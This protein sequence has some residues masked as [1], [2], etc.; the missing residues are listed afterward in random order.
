MPLVWPN[1]P[2]LESVSV[3]IPLKLVNCSDQLISTKTFAA[4]TRI[5]F[6]F[7]RW[8][9]YLS[10]YD[11]WGQLAVFYLWVVGESNSKISLTSINVINFPWPSS[12]FPRTANEAGGPQKTCIW[13]AHTAD[14]RPCYHSLIFQ[15]PI[16]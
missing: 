1:A 8:H 7:N 16:G 2:L 11:K 15:V 10:S 4:A 13:E 3:F 12:K 9:Y 6:K 5:R 14:C